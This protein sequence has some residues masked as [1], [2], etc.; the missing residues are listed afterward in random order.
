MK[1]ERSKA[2]R[3]ERREG[4]RKEGG[5]GEE[6]EYCYN[7]GRHEERKLEKEK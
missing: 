1:L 6:E 2:I 3:N 4:K 7:D 5:K